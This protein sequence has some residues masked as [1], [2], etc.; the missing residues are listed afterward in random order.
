MMKLSIVIAA[1]PLLGK[2]PLNKK[3]PENTTV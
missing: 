1:G 3:F 2:K